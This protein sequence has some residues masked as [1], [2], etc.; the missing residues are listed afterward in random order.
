MT[1]SQGNSESIKRGGYFIFRP[2]AIKKDGTIIRPKKGKM[3]KI[4]V[5]D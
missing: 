2:Y 3:L 5:K 1:M 4:W